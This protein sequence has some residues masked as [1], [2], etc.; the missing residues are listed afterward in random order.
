M[1]KKL[2]VRILAGMLAVPMT[3]TMG[4]PGQVWAAEEGEEE[5]S[6]SEEEPEQSEASDPEDEDTSYEDD[7]SS[8]DD[9]SDEGK[10]TE[11]SVETEETYYAIGSKRPFF[12]YLENSFDKVS[13]TAKNE[14]RSTK[15]NHHGIGLSNIRSACEKYNGSFNAHVEHD[16][17]ITELLIPIPDDIEKKQSEKAEIKASV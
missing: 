9:T 14:F 10:L 8:Y 5:S 7:Y 12:I 15:K 13:T 6:G 3:F 4:L 11:K 2:V 16:L 1:K 17:F